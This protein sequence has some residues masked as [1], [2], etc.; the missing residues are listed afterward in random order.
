[1]WNNKSLL[2][3]V[4]L[5]LAAALLGGPAATQTRMN[6]TE[7][8]YDQLGRLECMAVRMDQSKLGDAPSNACASTSSD[9]INNPDRI[10]RYLYDDAG[11]VREVQEAVGT[12]DQR[13][14]A[15][16]TYDANGLKTTEKDARGNLT[17]IYYDGFDRVQMVR[18]PS[19][20]NGSGIENPNDYESFQ[21][22]SNNN[23]TSWRRRDGQYI[24][25]NY[26]NLNRETLQ[27]NPGGLIPPTFTS[28]DL[29][30]AVLK[31]RFH[32]A[33]GPGVTYTYDALGRVTSA[34]D[35][36]NR[37]I[38]FGY[39]R[40]TP[41]RTALVYSDGAGLNTDD[42]DGL[43]RVRTAYF[44]EP[45]Q[46]GAPA[47]AQTFSTEGYRTSLI[48]GSGFTTINCNASNV[49]CFDRDAWG[50]LTSLAHQFA[51]APG[52]VSWGFTYNPASQIKSMSST[53]AV[54]DFKE[55]SNVSTGNTY[56]GL[57]RDQGIVSIGGFDARGNLTNEGQGGRS[58]NYDLYNR[59]ISVIGGSSNA[60]L[61]LTYDPEGRLAKYS[62][63]GGNTYTE[64]LYEGT[65]LIA[66]FNG[67]SPSPKRRYIHT[68]GVDEPIMWVNY[69]SN[70]RGYYYANYQ[71]SIIAT[72]DQAG[73]KIEGFKYGP[74]GE[75][76][77]EADQ[78]QAWTGRAFGYTGQYMLPQAQLYYYK[79]R[80]YDPKHGRFL[81]TDPIGSKD[82]LNL[83][84]YTGG[85]PINGTDPT[86]TQITMPKGFE[87]NPPKAKTVDPIVVRLTPGL[88]GLGEVNGGR[89]ALFANVSNGGQVNI[90]SMDTGKADTPFLGPDDIVLGLGFAALARKGVTTKLGTEGVSVGARL[91]QAPARMHDHH[92]FPQQFERFFASKGIAINDFTIT[93]GE[94]FHLK[95]L[96]GAGQGAVPGRWNQTWASWIEANPNATTQE[97]YHQAGRM[98]TDYKVDHLVIHPYR[99]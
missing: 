9:S 58:F 54:L 98:L 50:R 43:D 26:D 72:T 62:N 11:R 23:R 92:L 86:G 38:W 45:G 7:Y 77:N 82:D 95:A 13:S 21:Y 4:A 44:N 83:Y 28:Y 71:G 35:M 63:D 89:D 64:L 85:D 75:P 96:H 99:Q 20:T 65:K 91:L 49:T 74:Y 41:V 30:G 2:V 17:A 25:Y 57:N 1:M 78:E 33:D 12:S 37:T 27:Q 6:S 51:G 87:G 39:L 90:F 55:V 97:V 40:P 79:A 46:G 76:R 70:T 16:Y 8:K 59:L 56:D 52:R 5:S 36:N 60:N 81:Q 84:A 22:D 88:H 48:R 66:E 24:N 42:R 32:W 53:N 93:V 10:T 68:D 3:S 80:V 15:R 69:E 18:Y 34:A 31:K 47:W 61:L 29:T 14:Y 19:V 94:N 73:N 67:A